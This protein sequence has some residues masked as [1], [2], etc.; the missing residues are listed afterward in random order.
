L[1]SFT[2]ETLI[3]PVPTPVPCTF[4]VAIRKEVT[5]LV[6][7]PTKSPEP[8]GSVTQR[9]SPAEHEIILIGPEAEIVPENA[10]KVAPLAVRV[11]VVVSPTYLAPLFEAEIPAAKAEVGS[12]NN[13]IVL[14]ARYERNFFIYSFN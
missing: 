1:A 2:P 6:T 14:K 4:S 13:V 10:L 7:A 8:L 3:L 9:A 11:T 12:V 5:E